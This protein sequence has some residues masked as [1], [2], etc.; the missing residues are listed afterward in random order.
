MLTSSRGRFS[1]RRKI[2]KKIKKALFPSL[3]CLS[4]EASSF[5]SKEF[6]YWS[7]ATYTRLFLKMWQ[8]P[9]RGFPS[10]GIL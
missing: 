2:V 7:M 3:L 4:F 6:N 9:W 10:K 5:T 8:M 1:K